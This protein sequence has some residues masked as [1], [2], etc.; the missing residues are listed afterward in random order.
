VK[1]GT[2]VY[3]VE[4]MR[5]VAAETIKNVNAFMQDYRI[6]CVSTLNTADRMWSEYAED[7]KGI[8][9]RIEPNVAKDSKFQLFR[10]IVYREKRPPMYASTVDFQEGSL[11][12]DQERRLHEMVERIIYT[13]TLKWKHESE[14]RLAIP[15]MRQKEEAWNTLA[16]QPEE[17]TELYLG[18]AM[19]QRDKKEIVAMA[20]AVNP[21]IAIFQVKRN[22]DGQLGFDQ[23]IPTVVKA[24]DRLDHTMRI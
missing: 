10:P 12:G 9:L 23:I 20:R 16:Y 4:R 17:I 15:Y 14:Y 24:A 5:A 7:H 2:S 21:Q 6:L 1:E 22:A 8:A 11:F 13:K 3:D 19:E 18:L